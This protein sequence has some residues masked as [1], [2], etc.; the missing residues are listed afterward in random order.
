VL[1]R[2]VGGV[3]EGHANRL[4]F[5]HLARRGSP[6]PRRREDRAA[7]QCAA[8]G[9]GGPARG[10]PALDAS[11]VQPHRPPAQAPQA[12]GRV[13]LARLLLRTAARHA[14][15]PAE[16]GHRLHPLVH[17]ALHPLSRP[18]RGVEAPDGRIASGPPRLARARLV[19]HGD[20][21]QCPRSKAEGAHHHRVLFR[22][23]DVGVGRRADA[24]L[25]H[26]RSR[27]GRLHR[28]ARPD[29]AGPRDSLADREAREAG[30]QGGRPHFLPQAAR[31]HGQSPRLDGP[32]A[33]AASQ[34][35]RLPC[36]VSLQARA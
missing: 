21:V 17:C 31:G 16:Q 23:H 34:P 24:G 29:V 30:A 6:R 15:Q 9:A 3:E 7:S 36:G 1:R 11:V 5:A 4:H 25:G 18:C 26:L 22:S 19:P 35:R 27:N 32:T 10:P 2:A 14:S 33:H 8:A 12:A 13:R 28:R 20:A